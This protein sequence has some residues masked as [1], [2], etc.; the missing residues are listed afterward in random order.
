MLK[1]Y[2][3]DIKFCKIKDDIEQ[4][5]IKLHYILGIDQLADGLMKA[6]PKDA[7][8]VFKM[9]IKVTKIC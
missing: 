6:L 1:E 2:Y 4:G 3:T 8:K 7:Y 9:G 5:R